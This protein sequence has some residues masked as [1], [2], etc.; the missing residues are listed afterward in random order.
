MERSRSPRRKR[1]RAETATPRRGGKKGASS[2][3]SSSA[4]RTPGSGGAEST[5]VWKD[6]PADK[7]IKVSGTGKMAVRREMQGF[8]GRL[9]RASQ[10]SPPSSGDEEKRQ[11]LGRRARRKA[12]DEE[13]AASRH[14]LFSP[15]RAETGADAQRTPSTGR[16]RRS[17]DRGD[18][19]DELFSVLDQMEQKYA[20]PDVALSLTG[21]RPARQQHQQPAGSSTA[22]VGAAAAVAAAEVDLTATPAPSYSSTGTL[23]PRSLRTQ[24]MLTTQEVVR[25]HEVTKPLTAIKEQEAVTTPAKPV[26]VEEDSFDDLPDESWDLMD[27]LVSQRAMIEASHTQTQSQTELVSSQSFALTPRPMPSAACAEPKK[28]PPLPPSSVPAPVVRPMH[29]VGTAQQLERPESYRRFLVLEVDRDVINRSLLL[30]LLDDQDVQLEAVLTEDWYDVLVEAGD[31]VNI[32]FTEQDRSGVFSQDGP[33]IPA[34]RHSSRIQV[35]NMLNVVVVHPDILVSPT[36]VTTSFGCLRR[37]V[38]QETLAVSGTTGEKAFLG[39]LKHDL[40]EYAVR[41]GLCSTEGLFQEAKRIVHSN[42]LGLVECGL[43]EEKAFL[44][45]QRVIEGYCSWVGGAIAGSGTMLNEVPPTNESKARKEGMDVSLFRRLAEAH[46]EATQ[47]LSYQYRMN[48]DIMLL[49]NRL[50]YGDKLKCGSFKVA[51]NHLKLNWQ[52]QNT[53]GQKLLWPIQVLTNNHG[54]MFLDTDSM[55]EPTAESSSSVQTSSNGRR[56]MENIVEAQVVAG[57]VELLVLGSMPPDEIAVISPFRSQV[58]LIQQHLT[59]V[60]AFRRAGGSEW[61][62]SVEVSTIDK[63]QGKDKGVI[64]VSFVRCNEEKHVGELLTDWRR[65]NVALTRAKQKLLLVGSQ[66]TLGGGSALFHVL[67]DVVQEQQWGYKLPRDAAEALRQLAVSVAAPIEPDPEQAA[68]AGRRSSDN[69]KVSVLQRSAASNGDIESLVPNVSSI[70]LRP[71]QG[72]RPPQ[73]KPISRDIF[74]E[75]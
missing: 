39:T 22:T 75:M 5:I 32:V 26:V 3:S 30:R 8:V 29:T 69:V 73:M 6:S 54:V 44:E 55:G 48:R 51:S 10:Q 64:L 12:A 2:S 33:K 56:I 17:T 31:T 41:N 72:V 50:V 21:A 11:Q 24:E 19:Q 59:A 20:S 13:A 40:F 36:R 34:G 58:A 14:L 63:Y 43:N 37:A 65:I 38:L 67:S 45:L 61:V 60:A 7:Q 62:H 9:A 18:S 15:E 53:I 71:R 25:N 23:S 46:P 35:D 42:I 1:R 27:Q 66:S 74:G 28:V 52:R 4:S 47:Q 70:P 57:L 49:A 16:R 68:M